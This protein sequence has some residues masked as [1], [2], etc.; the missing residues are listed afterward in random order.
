MGSSPSRQK[1]SSITSERTRISCYSAV[2]RA[3]C[4]VPVS[5]DRMKLAEPIEFNRKSGGAKWRNLQF[6]LYVVE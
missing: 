2:D 3:A 6:S 4:A 1:G 5:R